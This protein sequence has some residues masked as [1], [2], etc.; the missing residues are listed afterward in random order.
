MRH[1][2]RLIG[3]IAGISITAL[4]A[5]A[6]KAATGWTDYLGGPSSSHF[7][8]LKQIT[9]ANVSKLDVAW[10]FP[11]GDGN[12]TF[13]PLVVDNIAYVAADGGSLV[14]LDATNGKRLWTHVFDRGGVKASI[15]GQRG[16]NYWEN[17]DR[18]ER[19]IFVTTGGFLYS[20]DALTGKEVD[21]FADH[22][23]LDLKTGIDRTP[24]S[25]GSRTPGRTFGNLIILGS[26]P[27]EGYLAP[28]GDIRAFDLH[29][30]QLTWTFHTIPRPGEPGYDT[31]PKDGYKYLGGVDVW[32]E[33]TV[34]EKRGIVYFP[35]SSTKY[36][37]YGG[38]RHGNNL[39]A[40]SLLA[41]DARTG[42]HLWHFQ[43]VHH[44]IW[45]YDPNQ[46]PQLATVRHNGKMVD[47]VALPSKN[48]FL[49]VFDRVTGMPL[50]P[51]VE[52]PVPQ[53]DLPGEQTSPTQP[54]PTV[55]PPFARQDM[56]VNDLYTS[57]MTPDEVT[58][59]KD[60]LSK[61]RH[62]LYTPPS[63]KYETIQIPSVTGGAAFFGSGADA[64][65]GM[66]FV[67]TR[68]LPSIL[69]MVPAGESTSANNGGLIP[70]RLGPPPV[71][72]AGGPSGRMNPAEMQAR[73]GRTVYEQNC[74][75]CHG[76]DLK[77]DRGPAI[78]TAASRLGLDGISN[79]V[80]HGR[81]AM[82]A[83]PTVPPPA[84]AAVTAFLKQPDLAPPGT[85]IGGN[86]FTERIEPDYPAYVD[87]RPQRYKTGYG[88]EGYVVT[89]PWSTITAYDLNTGKIAWQTPY[90]DTPQAG[91]SNTLRGN[92]FPKSGFVVLAS[93]LV[94][95][96]D[97]QGMLYALNEKTGKVVFSKKVPN[98]A[99]GV[100][101]V[102]EAVGRE[103]ILF[104]LTAGPAF[105]QGLRMAPGG[106][107]PPTGTR[108][109]VAFALPK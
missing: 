60:R 73:L 65:K 80:V 95:F 5:N 59:W 104:A 61:A 44:D 90:G 39:Y 79:I 58:W 11:A 71:R 48:G 38:D 22:G 21:S 1:L 16:L 47:I 43:T 9:P 40:D 82:P 7:S 6:Q 18:S 74:Q 85:G 56:T 30:G 10:S 107:N 2:C 84:V 17:K 87:P 69:K 105:S 70:S 57:F 67:E 109:Y 83:L 88:Q 75:V 106:V 32:G 78:D 8:P 72:P 93:G 108:S 12:Y 102:Y 98:G 49:Y 54:F 99:V 52:K 64:A 50:W 101:A 25:L 36:E 34:D 13:S 66:V 68:N 53:T 86:A 37:L 20:I 94:V 31:W 4:S 100:P 26:F 63:D 55:V 89:P 19:R 15:G 92:V 24:V 96:V 28:P 41:L 51:I 77:G 42:K 46:A 97:N 76:T 91:P 23:R 62:G 3:G 14:A 103:Y 29:T 27:G 45:D 33:F 81:G 35:V